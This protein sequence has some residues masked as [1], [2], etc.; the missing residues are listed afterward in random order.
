MSCCTLNLLQLKPFPSLRGGLRSRPEPTNRRGRGTHREPKNRLGPPPGPRSR[1][2]PPRPREE[3]RHYRRPRLLPSTSTR[4]ARQRTESRKQGRIAGELTQK[5]DW[6][7]Q[8]WSRIVFFLVC[9]TFI[10]RCTRS[11]KM[12]SSWSCLL[13]TCVVRTVEE[14]KAFDSFVTRRLRRLYRCSV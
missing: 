9:T 14:I 11:R 5:K 13:S 4:L 3:R 6:Q 10:R 2:G 1:R 8:Q 12:I 7:E